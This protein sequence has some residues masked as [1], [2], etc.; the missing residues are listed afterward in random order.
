MIETAIIQA[1]M[2]ST[3]LPGKVLLPI[4]EKP[5]LWYVVE[6]TRE[7]HSIREVLVATS[8]DP[9]D[10][11]IAAFCKQNR[12]LFFRGSHDDVLDRYFKAARWIKADIVVRITA[13]CP[14][15]DAGLIDR[16]IE[17]F[18][19][20]HFDYLS[21]TVERTFPRGFDFEVFTFAALEKAFR[22]AKEIPEREHV[23]PYI[24]ITHPQQFK[25]KNFSQKVD[26]SAYQ[27]TVDTPQDFKLLK[28]LIEEYRA[29]ELNYQ[30]IISF[31]D[32][33]PELVKINKEVK[34]KHYGQ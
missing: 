7:A 3:R 17:L 9:S 2:S 20:G 31:L 10:D 25:I 6:R 24:Y 19:K 27:I 23:T 15:I 4:A 28:I 5:M 29:D 34:R 21:N 13:D 1:R 33:H 18:T 30:Q 32:A 14:L 26:K 12:I 11:P 16:G 22:N 8:V